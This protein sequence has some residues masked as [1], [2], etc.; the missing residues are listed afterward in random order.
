MD[1]VGERL[2]WTRTKG[3][4]EP[5][6]KTL[7]R[8]SAQSRWSKVCTIG[9]TPSYFQIRK[10][11]PIGTIILSI[12]LVCRIKR[13]QKASMTRMYRGSEGRRR[14]RF[15]GGS[16]EPSVIKLAICSCFRQPG[17]IE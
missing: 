6:E 9:Q 10:P 7:K 8:R 17:R 15:L 5:A 13:S 4:R 2:P 14:E 16:R 3:S 11:D 12:C 1:V